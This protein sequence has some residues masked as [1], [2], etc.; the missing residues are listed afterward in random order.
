MEVRETYTT[1]DRSGSTLYFEDVR[2][3]L[4]EEYR[5][6]LQYPTIKEYVSSAHDK[7][8]DVDTITRNIVNLWEWLDWIKKK[9]KNDGELAPPMSP[10]DFVLL[11]KET[12][13]SKNSPDPYKWEQKLTDYRR[14]QKQ[15]WE[16]GTCQQQMRCSYIISEQ[17]LREGFPIHL[18]SK[19]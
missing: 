3:A 9:P 12:K 16:I 18:G 1:N 19:R 10:D 8:L 13:Y 7:K 17:Q 6:L 14:V 5:Y 2:E 4:P 11:V 15:E